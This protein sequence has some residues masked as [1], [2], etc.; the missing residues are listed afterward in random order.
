MPDFFSTSG[1]QI[2]NSL[3]QR[4]KL[5]GVSWFGLET[6]NLAP[7]GLHVRNYKDM[8]DQMAGLGFNTLRV[9]YSSAALEPGKMPP[10]GTIDVYN[11]NKELVGLTSLDILDKIID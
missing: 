3:G 5:T 1:N 6:P 4:V 8:I 2:V 11:A 7:D 10:T 9:P